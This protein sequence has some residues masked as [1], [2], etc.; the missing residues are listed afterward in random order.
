MIWLICLGLVGPIILLFISGV[1]SVRRID[2][3]DPLTP[4]N[5]FA[6]GRPC[7][8]C[9]GTIDPPHHG[10]GCSIQNRSK[11]NK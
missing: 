1:I 10:P 6:V 8:W 9:H 7:S 2:P 5:N 11:E 4:K 3:N